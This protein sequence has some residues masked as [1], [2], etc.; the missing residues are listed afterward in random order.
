MLCGAV[1]LVVAT[2]IAIMAMLP[3]NGSG[4]DVRGW[5]E[6]ARTVAA[7][8]DATRGVNATLAARLSLA[9][10]RISPGPQTRASLI[11]SFA[12]RYATPLTG[13]TLSILGGA[14]SLDGNLFATASADRTVELWDVTRPAQPTLLATLTGHTDWVLAVAFSP[15]GRTL[16]T[17]GNDG[18]A[19]LWDIT[20]PRKPV[21]RATLTGHNAHVRDVA[22]SPNGRLLATAGDDNTARLWDV[23]DQ[24]RPRQLS[25]LARH[26][27]WVQDV[28]FSPDGR[29]LATA[30]ADKN[31]PSLGHQRAHPAGPPRFSQRPHRL[32]VDGRLQPGR[33]HAGDRELRRHRSSVG[34]A[35][36]AGPDEPIDD[37][38]GSPLGP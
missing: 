3:A 12:G 18:T 9:A 2:V 22:F 19:R 35:R 23:T 28:A 14:F 5:A 1:A 20:D 29:R 7:D 24:A 30:S 33:E 21:T 32:R 36:C 10:Y 27:S 4:T 38:G 26:Q 15:D 13:H 8:A 17:G 37:Q 11:T 31:R 25:V 34:C 6:V 16:A